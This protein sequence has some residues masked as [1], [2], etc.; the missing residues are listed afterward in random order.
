M[1]EIKTTKIE[2]IALSIILIVIILV[3]VRIM[4]ME[5][6]DYDQYCKLKY[7]EDYEY[8]PRFDDYNRLIL[9]CK[10]NNKT[11]EF[12][13]ATYQETCKK[14]KFFDLNKQEVECLKE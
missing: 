6:V 4:I 1:D 14:P 2:V 10:N 9:E 7:G 3:T 13:V 8:Y 12:F 5:K 11:V